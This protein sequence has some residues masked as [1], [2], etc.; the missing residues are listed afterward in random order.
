MDK[1]KATVDKV[2]H[3]GDSSTTHNTGTTGHNTSST[4]A[5]HSSHTG[6]LLR[7]D[8]LHCIFTNTTS[9]QRC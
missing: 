1:I 7:S 3:G 9:S 5:P 6:K 2:L 8:L 4:G